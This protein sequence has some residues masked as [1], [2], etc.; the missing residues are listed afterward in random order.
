MTAATTATPDSPQAE[1]PRGR[2]G[3]SFAGAIVFEDVSYQAGLV[4]VLTDVS[5]TF[6]PGSVTCLLGPSGCGKTTILRLA[7]GVAKP[8]RGRIK[9]DGIEVAGPGTFVP[10]ERRNVGLMFQDYA[11]F[12]H[13]SVVQ[14]V[15]FGLTALSKAEAR[16]TALNALERVGLAAF[17]DR[18]P[19]SLSG[20]EQQR[21]AL[22]RAIVPRPQVILMDEPFAG[23]DQRLRDQVRADTLAVVKETRAT[24]V[25]VTHDPMEAVEFGDRILLMRNGAIVQ[26]GSPADLYAA[27]VDAAAAQF[28]SAHNVFEGQVEG[29]MV[30]LPIGTIAAPG[31]ADGDIVDVLLRPGGL[32]LATGGRGV[33]ALVREA[34][35]LGDFLRLGLAVWGTENLIVALL[36]QKARVR[37]GE[38]VN[39]VIDAA[40]VHVFKKS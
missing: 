3:A 34:R 31:F 12:P 35:F 6:E 1:L 18:F 40:A 33:P 22:A 28:F 29:G 30:A 19:N 25:L 7:A 39:I 20:G 2:A 27:P 36:P 38:T 21:V 13:L 15:A 11:L 32:H 8:T 23:L 14:N 24:A 26:Q 37:A 16:R 5:L 4:K 9:L 10:P 17:A